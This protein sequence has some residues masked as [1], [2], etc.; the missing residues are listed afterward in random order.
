MWIRK[1]IDL[2]WSDLCTAVRLCVHSAV[3][4]PSDTASGHQKRETDPWGSRNNDLLPTLSVRSGFDLLLTVL[5]AN[6]VSAITGKGRAS[7]DTTGDSSTS[8]AFSVWKPGDEILMSG[9]TIPDMPRIVK[10]HGL[11]PVGLEVCPDTMA[12]SV[13]EVAAKMTA[14]TRAIVMAHLFG[15]LCDLTPIRALCDAHGILLIEDCAQSWASHD[16]TEPTLADVSMFSFGTIKTA[17]ALGG[18]LMR[19]RNSELLAMMRQRHS[20][21]PVQTRWDFSR[22]ILRHGTLKALSARIPMAVLARTARLFG[23]THDSFV[24]AASRAYPGPDFFR[25]IRRQPCPGLL[26]MMAY[27]L[28]TYP[29]GAMHRRISLGTSAASQLSKKFQVPGVGAHRPTWWILS[30]LTDQPDQLVQSL[31][32]AGFDATPSSSLRPVGDLPATAQLLQ[33][34]VILPFDA[35]MPESEI[36][37]MVDVILRSAA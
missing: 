22:R 29:P 37:R 2:S 28:S 18:A 12:P 11:V 25:R 33:R 1:R 3:P 32:A 34:I 23:T 4:D 27:R 35:H 13:S 6:A 9:L 15:G 30:L 20:E 31:W 10:E 8:R 36:Q 17:T 5:M 16:H 19:I 26:A 7:S 21:W 14:Q 24:A